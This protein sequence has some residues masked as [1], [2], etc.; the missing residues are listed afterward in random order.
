MDR[1]SILAA[2]RSFLEERSRGESFDDLEERLVPDVLSS[3]LDAVE[4]V[5]H[6][7]EALG[8]EE[9]IDLEALGPALGRPITIGALADEVAAYL[10]ART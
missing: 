9:E 1:T 10:A 3:S 2:A 6:L 7:E 4:F 8:I 5:M